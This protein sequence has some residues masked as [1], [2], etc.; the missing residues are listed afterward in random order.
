MIGKPSLLLL[1]FLAATFASAVRPNV[2]FPPID[3]LGR[4]PVR[5]PLTDWI[6]GHNRPKA[7]LAI[8]DWKMKIDHGRI[9]LP[10]A[11]KEAGCANGRLHPVRTE[12]AECPDR[13]VGRI[14][15]KLGKMAIDGNAVIILTGDNGDG[16]PETT[17]SLREFKGFSHEGGVRVPF[18]ARWPGRIPAGETCGTPVIGKDIIRQS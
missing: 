10:D 16:H 14:A 1:A 17:G 9:P 13:G 7:K 6:A 4:Y 2:V 8:P 18:I 11:L 12:V 5:L 3:D 15:A